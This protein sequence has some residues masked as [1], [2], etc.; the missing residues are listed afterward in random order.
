V[1]CGDRLMSED[2]VREQLRFRFDPNDEN[3]PPVVLPPSGSI[4]W[5]IKD[6]RGR[7]ITY[8]FYLDAAQIETLIVRFSK[9]APRKRR[10]AVRPGSRKAFVLERLWYLIEAGDEDPV[11]KVMTLYEKQYGKDPQQRASLLRKF[12]RWRQ[13]IEK[14]R[15]ENRTN[16]MSAKM[17]VVSENGGLSVAL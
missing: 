1:W 17:S 5:E 7:P 15:A 4:G 9:S 8:T 11:G 2:E 3:K 16:K 10:R 12:R 6:K 14:E 13:D